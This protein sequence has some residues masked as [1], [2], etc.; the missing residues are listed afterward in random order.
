[1]HNCEVDLGIGSYEVHFGDALDAYGEWPTP[2]VIISDGAYGVGGFPG[3]PRTPDELAEWYRPHVEVWSKH[4]QPGTTLWFWNTEIGW[5]TVH[6]LLLQHGWDYVQAI[7]WD[8]GIAHVAGNVN[9]KTIRR[10]PVANEICVFYQRRLTLPT[11]EGEMPAQEWVRYEWKRSGLPMR[12][13]NEACGVKD[14]AT[15]K[16]F[17]TDWLWYFPPPLAME[18]LARYANEHGAPTDR[19][20]YSLDGHSALTAEEWSKLRYRWRHQHA[21][22]NMWQHP[23]LHNRERVKSQD[24]ERRAPR[25]YNPKVGVASAHLNQ[26]P[27]EFMRRIIEACTNIGDTVWEPF[28]GLCSGVVAAV[29]LGRNGYAAE[30]IRH[31]Y[32]L[33][34]ERIEECIGKARGEG[35]LFGTRS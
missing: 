25:V 27:L 18:Q 22:T 34:V 7:H 11:I 20:Y 32:E 15:R 29:N 19:P 3:D 28:G 23:P 6:P 10:F 33:A 21:L 14:A 13:A 5:A 2:T 17:A 1:M 35:R 8:K 9:G 24:G 26:K 16:Y 4:A 30:P 12:K 31:F